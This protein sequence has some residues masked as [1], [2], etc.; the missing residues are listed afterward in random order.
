LRILIL[1][2][3]YAPEPTGIAPYTASLAKGLVQHGH[4]VTVKTTHPHY[5]EWRIRE[6]YGLWSQRETLSGVGVHRLR[7]FVPRNPS[8]F[9][10]VISELSFG[11]RTIFGRWGRPDVVLLVSPALFA[12]SLASFR[13]R[14]LAPRVPFV[15]WV[16]DLY[17]LGVTETGTG[18]GRAA[19]VI[20]EVESALLRSATGVAVIHDR[21]AAHI[22]ENL[23]VESERIR[24]VR[25]WTHL[26]DLDLPPRLKTREK[27]NWSPDETIALHAGNMGVKQGL[28]NLVAAAKAADE[29]GERVRFVLLGKGNQREVI[30]AAAAG[31][32][33][34]QFIDPLPDLEYQA[35]MAAADVLI[36][37]EKPGVAEMAVPSKLTSYFSTG[38]PVVVATDEGSVTAGEIESSG[39]GLRVD[40]GDPE[41]LLEAIR[42]LAADELRASELGRRGRAF[43]EEVL[44]EDAAVSAYA[45]WLSGLVDKR[46]VQLVTRETKRRRPAKAQSLPR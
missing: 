30:R 40:A 12:S 7:H 33:N 27:Y 34:I 44:S 15:V 8:N 28:E 29:R 9:T 6:G 35:T 22:S 32:R 13:L 4:S 38:L 1:G 16:Q 19:R 43:R 21:F 24:V 5:P 20:S 45:N 42:A 10:R 41:A 26:E 46:R 36:V 31:I 37:N 17:G 3:N 14:F 2:L 11:L 39:G 25:N 18:G 23:R